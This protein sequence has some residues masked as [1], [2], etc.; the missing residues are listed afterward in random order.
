MV[1]EGYLS[2]DQ[3]AAVAKNMDAMTDVQFAAQM[4]DVGNSSAGGRAL[5][6]IEVGKGEAA[7]RTNKEQRI[8]FSDEKGLNLKSIA[9][10]ILTDPKKNSLNTDTKRLYALEAM[11][12]AGL[13]GDLAPVTRV[14]VEDGF[15]QKEM[16][17]IRKATGD[18]KFAIHTKLGFDSEAD[19]LAA[20]EKDP[21][22]KRKIQ[23]ELDANTNLISGGT[24]DN[25]YFANAKQGDAIKERA[26]RFEMAAK[27]KDLVGM[28]QG[29][30]SGVLDEY[31]KTGKW[32]EGGLSPEFKA[33][34]YQ[35]LY[36][37]DGDSGFFNWND[38]KNNPEDKAHFS[39]ALKFQKLAARVNN[40]DE[41]ADMIAMN[42]MTGGALV[43]G[44]EGQLKQYEDA[45][46]RGMRT[47]ETVGA[48]GKKQTQD[49]DAAIK[50]L[51]DAIAKLKADDGKGKVMEEMT[52]KVLKVERQE[53]N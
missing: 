50:E 1:G 27:Y 29:A 8:A 43:E 40:K 34:G 36:D 38:E 51:T 16:D 49:A 26:S 35:D 32:T 21:G 3:A 28:E 15:S 18:D 33:D 31:M 24:A 48:D 25:M 17:D 52:V 37:N 44:M 23:R 45:K 47:I 41:T 20:Q 42:A 2:E 30:S 5:Y 39:Q 12:K 10:A 13:A 9:N 6:D 19:M 7:S 4:T 22:L 53:P 11:Q 46:S 14:N